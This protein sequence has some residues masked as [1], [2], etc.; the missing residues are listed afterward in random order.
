MYLSN[1]QGTV[2]RGKAATFSGKCM[3]QMKGNEWLNIITACYVLTH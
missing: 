3:T 2:G 1:I